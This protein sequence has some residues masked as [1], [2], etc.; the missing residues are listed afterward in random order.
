[1][2]DSAIARAEA[3]D[4]LDQVLPFSRRDVLAELL[5]DDDVETL[6]HLAK[7]G[8]GDN[9][10][11]ALSSDLAYLEAWCI[12]ATGEPLP[13]PAP[14][15]LLLKFVAHHLW[16]PARR[17]TA[18]APMD[19]TAG[20]THH[21][22]GLSRLRRKASDIPSCPPLCEPLASW[23]SRPFPA[24]FSA[25]PASS[26]A[27]SSAITIGQVENFPSLARSVRLRR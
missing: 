14:E 24:G 4:A 10:L 3:L 9:S 27:L 21:H 7:E 6:R 5:T 18:V 13:W 11:R 20:A 22:F 16:D 17:E 15:A 26:F 23:A 19:V 1:M 25:L 8:M 2:T 12:A